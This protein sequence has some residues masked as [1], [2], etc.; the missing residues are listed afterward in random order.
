[1]PELY[2]PTV[3]CVESIGNYGR[4]LAEPLGPGFGVTLGNAL[5]RVLLSSLPG[6]AVTWVK[7][8]GIQHEFSP[9]PCVKEDAM[10]FLL[11]IKQLRLCPLASQPGQLFLEAEGEGKVCAGDIK[12]SASFRVANPELYLAF[13]DSPQAKLYVEL[14]VELGRGYVPAKSA[15]GL[16]VG[17][18]PVDAIFTPVRTV[19]FSVE[20]VRPGQEESPEKFIL[21][22]WTD[23]TI[24]PWEALSQSAIILINQF[25]SFRDLEVPMAR[26]L[27]ILPEQYDTPLEELDL[28]TRSYNSLRR[29]G[30]FTL[31]QLLEQGKEGLP[32]LP[33]LGAK[34]RA[35][36]EEVIAKLGS[37]IPEKKSE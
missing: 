31:G 20:S 5:R 3:T 18:L 30:I 15:D 29:A 14:N 27:S 7:I 33:G 12:P 4:F 22:I 13:L 35:E 24:F 9:I 2:I 25:S 6:A 37:P 26:A 8:E 28:S 36:V 1:M 23:G 16:P 34:S 17:A 11:N 10:E 32:P 19:N 21:E